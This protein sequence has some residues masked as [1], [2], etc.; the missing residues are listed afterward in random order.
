MIVGPLF[1]RWNGCRLR[2]FDYHAVKEA[3][4]ISQVRNHKSLLAWQQA[5]VVTKG[6]LH[7]SR[8]SWK[9]QYGAIFWQLQRSSVSV[10][11]NIAE[12]YGFGP[13]ARMRNHLTI[14]YASAIETEDLLEL[15]S[16][17]GIGH[18]P[19]ISELLTSCDRSQKLLTGLIK[20][21][22]SHDYRRLS[23]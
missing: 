2:L 23:E 8:T 15:L 1:M 12:G 18:G 21:Y 9:P 4:H 14:A 17:E 16:E 6:V 7:L 11:I 22:G 19:E 3:L 13:S 20:K 5:K 10:Q